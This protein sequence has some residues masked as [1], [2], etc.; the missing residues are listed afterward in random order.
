MDPEAML[1][2]LPVKWDNVP[3]SKVVK[4][5]VE[6]EVN[7]ET[8]IEQLE[9]YKLLQTHYCQQ[10]VSSTISYGVDEVPA[11]IEWLLE[12]WDIYVGVS[13]LFRTDP[14]KTA[15]ECG[16]LYLPQSVV[17]KAE[18]D[19]YVANLQPIDLNSNVHS[20]DA[21]LEDECKSGACPIR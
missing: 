7:L 10:N 4:N 15:E 18:Y 3:F 6:M 11:I 1:I 5:G 8:A 14:T 12:N 13:F 17:T 2:T 21:E 9:R 16:Y 20:L 19:A